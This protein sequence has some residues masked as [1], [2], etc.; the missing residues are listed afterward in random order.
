VLCI[1]ATTCYVVPGVQ[2][3]TSVVELTQAGVRSCAS[4]C[5]DARIK[6][7]RG[8]L[9]T[10]GM[11]PLLGVQKW[12]PKVTLND[13]IMHVD[14]VVITWFNSW[15]PIPNINSN[16]SFVQYTLYIGYAAHS[17][18]SDKFYALTIQRPS[19]NFLNQN[20]QLFALFRAAK[21]PGKC[22]QRLQ[23]GDI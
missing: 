9:Y 10:K 11:M 3:R 22:Q 16:R 6:S 19:R 18:T 12:L 1:T 21:V 23:S 14:R 15:H 8:V 17:F 4:D 20:P 13:Y 7:L 2:R 5:G